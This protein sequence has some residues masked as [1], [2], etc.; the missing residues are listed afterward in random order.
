M[1]RTGT[2][3]TILAGSV[4]TT[5]APCVTSR[6]STTSTT[7]VR[8]LVPHRT[9][10][11]CSMAAIGPSRKPGNGCATERAHC[12]RGF[13]GYPYREFELDPAYFSAEDIHLATLRRRAADW[14]D[15]GIGD[16]IAW[17]GRRW[18]IERHLHV[19][20]RKLCTENQDT[21]RMGVALLHRRFSGHFAGVSPRSS[22]VRRHF[23]GGSAKP[24]PPTR[25]FG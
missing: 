24:P 7:I 13:R 4:S 6:S 16:W 8:S 2:S 3:R 15:W 14:K 17:L 5:S 19:A 21:F 9:R 18:C 1:E 11:P 25:L 23:R 20:L 12:A 22:P 10:V